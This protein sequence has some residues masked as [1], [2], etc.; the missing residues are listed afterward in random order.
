MIDSKEKKATKEIQEIL[1]KYNL[2]MVVGL[3][4]LDYQ[5]TYYLIDK[6]KEI[7]EEEFIS[8]NKPTSFNQLI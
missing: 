4:N 7:K 3:K 6:S 1:D 5:I 8:K 2:K